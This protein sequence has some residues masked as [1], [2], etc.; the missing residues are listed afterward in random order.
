MWKSE[1][2][3]HTALRALLVFIGVVW[4]GSAVAMVPSLPAMSGERGAKAGD[5]RIWPRI[6]LE[7]GYDSNV[8]YAADGDNYAKVGSPFMLLTPGIRLGNPDGR[9]ILLSFDASG[10]FRRFFSGDETIDGPQSNFGTDATLSMEFFPRRSVSLEVYDTVTHR[11][12]TPNFSTTKTFNRIVNT[13]GARVKLH[14]GGIGGRRALELSVGYAFQLEKFIDFT[15]LDQNQHTFG[16]LGTWKFFPKTALFA[17]IEFAIRQWEKEVDSLGRTNSTPVRAFFG[18]TGFITKKVSTT[19][20]LGYGTGMYEVGQDFSGVLGEAVLSYL[21]FRSTVFSIAYTRD[22]RD[23]LYANFYGHDKVSLRAMQQF[24]GRFNIKTE[25]GY[26]MIDYS[27]FDPS[28]G[29]PV[30]DEIFKV[31][32]TTDRQETALDL[33][34]SMDFEVTRYVAFQL[35][36]RFRE[37]FSDFEERASLDQILSVD[38]DIIDVGGYDRHMVFGGIRI[39]Y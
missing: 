25:V 2:N 33:L 24:L 29:G 39:Q 1:F 8:F 9:D 36:Y 17:D 19:V 15:V 26:S 27:Y 6:S 20:K 22:F 5:F 38:D 13:A 23:S 31:V 30:Y 35:S 7:G 12:E 4:M 37:V 34:T 10:A 32:N 18:L 11:L 28:F 21:P 16:F 3:N 14:P